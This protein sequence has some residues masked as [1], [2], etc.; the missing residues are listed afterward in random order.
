MSDARTLFFFDFVDPGCYLT[1]LRLAE[2]EATGPVESV[3]HVPFELRPIPEPPIDPDDSAW[4]AYWREMADALA[5]AEVRVEP[6]RRVPW[7]RKAHEL[8]LLAHEAS[9]GDEARRAIFERFHER[10]DDIGRV[11]VLLQVATELGIDRT[12]AKATLDVDRWAGEVLARRR[13]AVRMG[14][15]GVPTLAR[16]P[17]R[18][19]GVHGTAA[20]RRFLAG[21]T[22]AE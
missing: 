6:P 9:V 11:D 14:I 20:L 15:R 3:E 2:L 18:L 17:E 12:K 10:G 22:A 1:E 7:T 16:G 4:L 21:T 19:E 13:E 5:G 8:V